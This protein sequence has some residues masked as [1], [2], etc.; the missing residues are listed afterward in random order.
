MSRRRRTLTPEER[1]LW[2]SVARKADPIRKGRSSVPQPAPAAKPP[3]PA[4]PRSEAPPPLPPFRVGSKVDHS[5]DHDLMASLTEQ[6]ARTPVQ[7]HRND[8]ARLKR[9]KRQPEARIDLHGMTLA[10]A[11]PALMRFITGAHAKGLR[12]VL[13]ITGK[14]KDRDEPGPIPRRLGALRHQVPQ[15]LRMAPLA[16]L[17]LDVMPANQ[18]HGGDGALYVT[19]R[20]GR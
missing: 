20:R 13:V 5:R 14:G 8:A 10:E 15:W 19:L 2:D 9:G 6:M 4:K 7:M 3:G 17:V 18:R 11:H 16:A 12:L 1:A